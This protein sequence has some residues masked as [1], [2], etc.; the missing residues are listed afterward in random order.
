MTFDHTAAHCNFEG[1]LLERHTS[2]ACGGLPS[3]IPNDAASRLS[4]SFGE[5]AATRWALPSAKSENES[6]LRHAANSSGDTGS[7]L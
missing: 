5:P 1:G 7:I 6:C 3:R 2:W 4:R